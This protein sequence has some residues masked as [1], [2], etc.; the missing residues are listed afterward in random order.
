MVLVTVT[1]AVG[2]R[3]SGYARALPGRLYGRRPVGK[4]RGRSSREAE[5]VLY[6]ACAASERWAL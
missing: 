5:A 2:D 1:W 3:C 6:P 4:W